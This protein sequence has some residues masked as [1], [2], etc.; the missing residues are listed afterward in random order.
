MAFDGYREVLRLPGV[1]RV[2]TSVTIGRLAYG[3][4]PFAVVVASA[5]AHGFA[6]A[7]V[8]SAV[9]ML[10]IAVPAPTRGRSWISTAPKC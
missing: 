5:R 9:L 8:A 6:A 2:L 7:G 3:I 10:A 4:I 1:G